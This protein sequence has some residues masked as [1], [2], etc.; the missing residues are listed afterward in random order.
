MDGL[1]LTKGSIVDELF[2]E[3]LIQAFKS[4]FLGKGNYVDNNYKTFTQQ[5]MKIAS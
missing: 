4:Q 3:N 1:K 5:I 2:Q